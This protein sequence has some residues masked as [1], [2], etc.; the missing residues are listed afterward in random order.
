MAIRYITN[1]ED[2]GLIVF[3]VKEDDP[4]RKQKMMFELSRTTDM[5]T[6]FDPEIHTYEVIASGELEGHRPI[7]VLGECSVD[8]LPQD[9]YFRDAWDWED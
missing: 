7:S 2:G 1:R 3:W 4:V 9:E 6:H 5:D 8:D